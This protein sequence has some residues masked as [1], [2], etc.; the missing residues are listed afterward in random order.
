MADDEIINWCHHS[1]CF[2]NEI[3]T[4]VTM[5]ICGLGAT[6]YLLNQKSEVTQESEGVPT[7]SGRLEPATSSDLVTLG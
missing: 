2:L 5:V 3:V 6:R 7:D 1:L 4:L